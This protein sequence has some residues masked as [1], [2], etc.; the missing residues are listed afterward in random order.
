MPY[1]VSTLTNGINIGIPNSFLRSQIKEYSG[2]PK[3]VN[4]NMLTMI[5]NGEERGKPKNVN[6]NMKTMMIWYFILVIQLLSEV[7]CTAVSRMECLRNLSESE[8]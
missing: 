5:K 1:L 6:A 2:K 8:S 4:A 7:R 3:N